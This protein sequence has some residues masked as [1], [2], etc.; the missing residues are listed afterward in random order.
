MSPY[1]NPKEE[2]LYMLNSAARNAALAMDPG[3]SQKTLAGGMEKLIA[4]VYADWN[5]S[6]DRKE[7]S[8]RLAMEI[9]SLLFRNVVRE[10][11][12]RNHLQLAGVKGVLDTLNNT[13]EGNEHYASRR[14]GLIKAIKELEEVLLETG[15]TMIKHY[16]TEQVAVY[17]HKQYRGAMGPMSAAAREGLVAALSELPEETMAAVNAKDSL[18]Y[19]AMVRGPGRR[20][21]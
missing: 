2:R 13:A 9:N 1:V 6:T 16:Q 18:T 19:K 11:Y 4:E 3:L 21:A 8:R 20:R 17:S 10:A 7:F 14:Y 12:V 5:R 15:T